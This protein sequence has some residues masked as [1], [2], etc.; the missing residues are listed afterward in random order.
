MIRIIHLSDLHMHTSPRHPDN[1][2]AVRIVGH[3]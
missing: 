1:R 3:C 2:N